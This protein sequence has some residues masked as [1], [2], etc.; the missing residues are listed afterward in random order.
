MHL[1]DGTADMSA[2]RVA[3]APY[4]CA[5][6]LLLAAEGCHCC[7]ALLL[8]GTQAKLLQGQDMRASEETA[9]MLACLV[10]GLSGAELLFLAAKGYH[11]YH[12]ML[13]HGTQ[14]TLHRREGMSV[15]GEI[16]EEPGCSVD[17]APEHG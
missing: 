1:A 14:L 10:V 2:C 4:Y 3:V 8:H 7:H 16:A 5:E 12:T 11:C 15:A 17:V 13:L 6:Q 9:D